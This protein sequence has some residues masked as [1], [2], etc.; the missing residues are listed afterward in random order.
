M[1][2]YILSYP[3]HGSRAA[4]Q[5]WLHLA[6]QV[7]LAGGRILVLD[8][9][10]EAAAEQAQAVTHAAHLGAL[11][12]QP[13]T[14]EPVFLLNAQAASQSA[15]L[16]RAGLRV[17]VAEHPFHGQADLI[18]LPRSRFLLTRPAGAAAV[19][20]VLQ[21]LLPPG[22]RLLEVPL[23][24]PLQHGYQALGAVVSAA[25]HAVLLVHTAGLA[26][27]G[28]ADL[29]RFAGSEVDTVPLEGD[30][31]AAGATALLSVRS[32]LLHN[33]GLSA[34]LRG[35]LVRHGFQLIEMPLA[36]ILCGT[37]SGP[38]ALV[39]ELVGYVLSEDAPSYG[40]RRDSLRQRVE[41]YPEVA[42]A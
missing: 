42:P 4:F 18:A 29:A 13:Q 8:P 27:H 32:H 30:D 39:N 5:E 40:L 15:A 1:P 33:P 12:P 34:T 22:A 31:A 37:A 23:K 20:P 36:H 19:S 38:R 21:G 24:A 11:F 14:R 25:G 28:L 3:G 35:R 16:E 10:K 17:R 41:H 2:T 9:S 7:T 6:D 26:E